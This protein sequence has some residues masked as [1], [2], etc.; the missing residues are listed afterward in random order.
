MSTLAAL[1]FPH[2]HFRVVLASHACVPLLSMH[3]FFTIFVPGCT[4][5][6]SGKLTSSMNIKLIVL[7]QNKQCMLLKKICITFT[8]SN[9]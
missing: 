8:I 7:E 4:W 3:H 9:Q 1:M 2:T 5:V 6:P